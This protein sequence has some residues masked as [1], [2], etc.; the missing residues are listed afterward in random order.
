MRAACALLVILSVASA[1]AQQPAVATKIP[2]SAKGSVIGHV[3]CEETELPMRFAEI[4]L[5]PR[6]T[7]AD[8]SGVEDQTVMS[9]PP[10]PHLRMVLGRTGLN[11]SFRMDGVPAG[12]YFAGAMMTGY[13]TP[14]IPA[15]TRVDDEQLNRLI[16]SLPTVHVT[17]GQVARVNLALR[18]GAVIAGRG[19]FAD[20]GPAIGA[21]VSWELAEM[22]LADESVRLAIPT[23]LQQ[24]AQNFDYYTDH[25]HVVET[26][27]EGR[28][29]IFGL[30]PGKYIVS[31]ILASQTGSAAQV[32][33]S[34]G[35]SPDPNGRVHP[36]PEMT[37]V[38]APGVFRRNDA[39]VFDISGSEQVMN[40]DIKVDPSGLHTVRGK[41]LAGEDRHV[42]SQAMVRIR[43]DGGKDVGKSVM[44]EDDGSFQFDYLLPGNYTLEVMPAIDETSVGGT[45]DVPQVLRRY[46]MAKLALVVGG[47]DLVLDDLVLTALKPGEKMEYP[48]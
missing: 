25:R 18:R 45:T 37:T 8:L 27:D 41:V 2:Q 42:P 32:T 34:D 20:G 33:M 28:Y 16:A 3:D 48:Q 10:K 39:R 21:M 36:Y 26:D 9:N 35:S 24:I 31:T 1:W 30:S 6:P 43:E 23:R 29:R 14:G 17:V 19:Q 38:Y 7:E 22:N 40:A 12:D 11:G 4:R 13:V 5:V 15:D 46:K 47:R 44:I